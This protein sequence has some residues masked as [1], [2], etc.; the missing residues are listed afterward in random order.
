[1]QRAG[2]RCVF[3]LVR[4]AFESVKIPE[5]LRKP[6]QAFSI[7]PEEL[8]EKLVAANPAIKAEDVAISCGNNYLTGVSVCMDKQ[9]Q[10]RTCEGIH[11]CRANV[12][13]VPPVR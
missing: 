1:M 9:L 12:I 10:P 11:D 3:K 13:K 4:R 2:G 6:S 7:S 5:Q 8:K